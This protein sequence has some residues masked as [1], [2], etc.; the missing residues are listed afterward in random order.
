MRNLIQ[1]YKS[2]KNDQK[3][4]VYCK[5]LADKGDA[6]CQAEMSYCFMKGIGT[7]KNPGE[8]FK[9]AKRSADQGHDC[10]LCNLGYCYK[11]GLGVE[12]DLEKAQE[13]LQ[14]SVEKGFTDAKTFLDETE[15]MLKGVQWR[16]IILIKGL[17]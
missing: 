4:V 11:E 10:G 14:Q 7:N 9:Y 15:V 13:L 16:F 1:I 2:Q 12:I 5:L 3:V 8:A 6:C 17:K